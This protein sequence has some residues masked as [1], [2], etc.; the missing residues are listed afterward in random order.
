VR[1]RVVEVVVLRR[2]GVPAPDASQ[3]PELLE[4]SDVGEVPDER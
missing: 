3:E 1:E 4:V 2:H